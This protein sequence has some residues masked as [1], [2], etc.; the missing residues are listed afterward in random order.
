[1]L[2]PPR[3]RAGRSVRPGEAWLV[4]AGFVVVP[5]RWGR[6]TSTGTAV[7]HRGGP[8][9]G[10]GLPRPAPA[11]PAARRRLGRADRSPA[12]GLPAAARRHRRGR[13]TADRGDLRAAG[14]NPPR[15][16]LGRGAGDRDDRHGRDRAP[17]LDLDLH[18]GSHRGLVLLT[19]RHWTAAARCGGP[20]S[21]W[22]PGWRCRCNCCQPSSW[23]AAWP[24]C[25]WVGR[26]YPLRS[27]GR[28]RSPAHGPLAAPYLCSGPALVAATG[29]RGEHRRQQ[30]DQRCPGNWSSQYQ[31]VMVG[32]LITARA[33]PGSS[34][35]SGLPP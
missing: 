8:A 2:C 20:P 24:R 22:S 26:V 4:A 12:V 31:L 9:P 19:L 11:G 25:C 35:S 3:T 13:R 7:L 28:G 1:M 29:G 14:R 6:Y 5:R 18:H 30:L 33:S 34:R 17:V 10:L 32:L 21:A 27:H 16:D 15:P 23:P